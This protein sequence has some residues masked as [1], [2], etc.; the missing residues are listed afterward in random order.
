ME[1]L[2]MTTY[3]DHLREVDDLLQAIERNA[4]DAAGA[5][6]DYVQATEFRR[7]MAKLAASIGK[8]R[9]QLQFVANVMDAQA[10]GEV[11][12]KIGRDLGQP[13]GTARSAVDALVFS[14][15]LTPT[16]GGHR[17]KEAEG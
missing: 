8:A 15:L 16:I 14:G 7:T 12:D 13:K 3:S 17:L 2:T 10:A 4:V 11:P 9:M 1:Q 6:H 5:M